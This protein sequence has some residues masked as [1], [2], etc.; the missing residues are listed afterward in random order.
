MN[1]KIVNLT[2]PMKAPT[3]VITDRQLSLIQYPVA[4][5]PKLDGFRA[6]INSKGV[7]TASMKMINNDFVQKELKH[8]NLLG[9]DG[10]LIVGKPNDRD[11]FHNSSGPLRRKDEMPDFHF[12]VFDCFLY[13]ERSYNR[14]WLQICHRQYATIHPRVCILPQTILT[15]AKEVLHYEKTILK[16][17]YE[18]IIIRSITAPYKQ[19]RATFKEDYIFKRKPFVETEARII[20]FEEQYENTNSQTRNN[21]GLATRSSHKDNLR[22]KDTL[23]AFLL[24]SKLW[25]KAF[26]CGTG[27]GLT[28]ELR[29]EIWTHQKKY[30]N[31]VI[32]F[33]YQKYGSIDA[34]R[35][36]VF[37][38]FRPDWDIAEPV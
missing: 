11:A 3:E 34:P 4:G 30:L 13:P 7:A 18:G 2:R 9:L 27:I 35:M 10:E 5:S 21:M 23:G 31:K 38:R 15:S 1:N 14:R 6:T 20:G 12:Y 19:G 25:T 28:E 36:P 32:T 16:Q 17:G 22:G 37:L 29:K 24:Q 8:K 33:K 26:T